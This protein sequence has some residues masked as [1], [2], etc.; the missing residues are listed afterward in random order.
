GSARAGHARAPSAHST[1]QGWRSR[2]GGGAGGPARRGV[3]APHPGTY[4]GGGG[5]PGKLAENLSTAG[6]GGNDENNRGPAVADQVGRVL[7]GRIPVRG[8]DHRRGGERLG[9]DHHH[10]L[11][12]QPGA[13]RDAAADQQDHRGR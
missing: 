3:R 9:R 8:G 10:H 12:R 13:V 6:G 11:R 1:H 7:L 4:A 2:Q 5:G